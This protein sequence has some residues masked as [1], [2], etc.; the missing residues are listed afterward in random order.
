MSVRGRAHRLL[1]R[2]FWI[3]SG[4]AFSRPFEETCGR[5]CSKLGKRGR[6]SRHGAEVRVQCGHRSWSR[7]IG[8]GCVSIVASQS[9][10]LRSF[11]AQGGLSESA[12]PQ[13]V[14]IPL[15]TDSETVFKTF[16]G[17]PRPHSEAIALASATFLL[18]VSRSEETGAVV[19]SIWCV[20]NQACDPGLESG[21]ASEGQVFE[22]ELGDG[23]CEDGL[24]RSY[25]R[26]SL[27]VGI[28]VQ[29]SQ[30]GSLGRTDCDS[31]TPRKPLDR[32]IS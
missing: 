24:R 12:V 23:S 31:H 16:G 14:Y 19:V 1:G 18:R 3:A 4:C 27:E 20:W 30:F 9:V 11:L 5:S 15:V 13:S 7:S 17:A 8:G 10:L 32:Y 2:V 22:S 28:S 6:K 26:V 29:L 25:Y 21:G